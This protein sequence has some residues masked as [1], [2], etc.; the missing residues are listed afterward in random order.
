MKK[1]LFTIISLVLVMAMMCCNVSV[2]AATVTPRWTNC[3][4]YTFAFSITDDGIAHVNIDYTG[5]GNNFAEARSTVK[6]QKRFLLAFWSTVDIGYTD[7]EWVESSTEIIDVF[8]NSFA[9]SDTGTYRAV[10]TLE[11]TGKNGSVDVIEDKI[12]YKYE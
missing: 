8:Y 11:I 12:E 2:F 9:L 5:D 7:N 10:L 3:N 4:Q 1:K 6:I